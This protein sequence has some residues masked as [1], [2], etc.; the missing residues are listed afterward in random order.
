MLPERLSDLRKF[1]AILSRLERR[2][3]GPRTLADCSGRMPWPERGVF[4]FFENGEQRSDS[5]AGPRVVYV[6]THA[7]TRGSQTTL[8]HRLSQHRGQADNGGGNHRGSIFRLIVGASLIERDKH[9]YPTWSDKSSASRDVRDREHPSE[10]AVSKIIR[11][12]PFLW[13]SIEDTP[14]PDSLRSYVKRN[15]IALLS[16]YERVALDPSSHNWLGR[17]CDRERVRLSGLWD[18]N[19]VDETYDPAFLDCLDRLVTEMETPR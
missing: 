16:N 9:S 17:F 7:I 15:A 19:H 4:F 13:L 8:W 12:M 3:K 2:L 11:A 10:C 1:Y 18:S 6:G 5:G 14:G